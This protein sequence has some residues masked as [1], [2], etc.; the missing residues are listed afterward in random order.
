[1]DE[2]RR[3]YEE[4]PDNH[5]LGVEMAEIYRRSKLYREANNILGPILDD[6]PDHFGAR[7][8]QARVWRQSGDYRIAMNLF[9]E[10]SDERPDDRDL[11]HELYDAQIA[12]LQDQRKRE[13]ENRELQSEIE[14]TKV[15]RDKNRMEHLTQMVTDHPEKDAQRAELGELLI[16]YGKIDEAIELLQRLLH[17]RAWMG[18]G[19][20]L[21]GNCFRAKR[22][23]QLAVNQYRKALEFYKDK[24]Y[25]HVPSEDLKA[26]W[27]YMGLA[28]EELGNRD[29]AREAF[30]NIYAVD[31]N[32]KDVRKR[33]E[34][35]QRG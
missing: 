18:K 19:Y 31:I 11:K 8:E 23:N 1:M 15:K 6:N 13:P 17:H 16:Q 27:Y 2:L 29:A 7:R 9:K 35:M 4:N 20:Y 24:G 25:S 21:L 32:Y 5:D 34:E 3:A 30:G 26:V 10:L 14:R 12:H 33:Y 28:E 22:D